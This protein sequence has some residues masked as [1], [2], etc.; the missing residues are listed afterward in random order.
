MKNHFGVRTNHSD[1]EEEEEEDDQ[2]WDD[3]AVLLFGRRGIERKERKRQEIMIFYC[4]VLGEK[5]D[6]EKKK[7]SSFV[8]FYTK[9]VSNNRNREKRKDFFSLFLFYQTQIYFETRKMFNKR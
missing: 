3:I 4:L 7:G 9:S 6:R 1:E 5:Y 8:L 2:I